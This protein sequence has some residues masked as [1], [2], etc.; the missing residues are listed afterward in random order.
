MKHVVTD[1][2]D[3]NDPILLSHSTQENYYFDSFFG[4]Y[5]VDCSTFADSC[6][7]YKILHTTQVVISNCINSYVSCTNLG[8]NS[9]NSNVNKYLWLLFFDGSKSSEGT[10][11]LRL[12]DVIFARCI[13]WL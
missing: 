7:Q 13:F 8:S 3:S 11:C 5:V 10:M 6:D 2:N 4:N 12:K 9:L 1:L